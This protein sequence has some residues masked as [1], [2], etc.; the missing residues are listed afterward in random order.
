M[1]ESNRL[2]GTDIEYEEFQSGGTVVSPKRSFPTVPDN[3]MDVPEASDFSMLV[4]LLKGKTVNDIVSV[5]ANAEAESR[6]GSP[7]ATI[8]NVAFELETSDPKLAYSLHL[9]NWEKLRDSESLVRL[10][11]LAFRLG[12]K[13]D[14]FR[15]ARIARFL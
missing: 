12:K 8:R 14:G 1:S 10:V 9:A 6:Y 15:F 13:A 2:C 5:L 4:D 11:S 7:T 3:G